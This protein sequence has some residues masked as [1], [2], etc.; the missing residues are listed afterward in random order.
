[1]SYQE[2][3]ANEVR[4]MDD[5]EVVKERQNVIAAL[6]SLTDRY[7]RLNAEMNR[8]DTLRWMVAP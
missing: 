7:K 6:A 8:R 1:V 2:D 4:R 3:E 5:F